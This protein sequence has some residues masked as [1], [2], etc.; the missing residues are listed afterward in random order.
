MSKRI[1]DF[2][3][4]DLGILVFIAIIRLVLHTFTNNQYG[5][6]RDELQTLDD[7]RHLDFGFVVYPP[8]TPLIARLELLLFGDSLWGFRV[9]SAAAVSIIMVLVGLMAK[10]LGGKRHTQL[11]GL[12][13]LV[14]L[15][16]LW[17]KGLFCNMYRLTIFGV[18][19]LL[20]FSLGC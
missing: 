7:A 17:L 14:L 5:F 6:H 8:I 18:S 20:I 9:F 13:L 15:L 4:S 1:I 3:K 16:F 12:S 10:Q 11:L 2:L 19:L